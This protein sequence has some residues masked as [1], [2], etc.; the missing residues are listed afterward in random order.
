MN[1]K[2]KIVANITQ[3]EDYAR[4]CFVR[5]LKLANGQ[6]VVVNDFIDKFMEDLTGGEFNNPKGEQILLDACL[7]ELL[8]DCRNAKTPEETILYT[9]V[10]IYISDHVRQCEECGE[11]YDVEDYNDGL[12]PECYAHKRANDPDVIADFWCDC[13][14]D[15]RAREEMEKM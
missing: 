3:L 6:G 15:D 7:Y 12:C 8:P 13:E 4:T 14:R 9:L 2:N 10:D 11:L 5:I 1:Y